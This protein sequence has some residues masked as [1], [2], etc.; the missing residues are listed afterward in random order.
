ME[1]TN[2]KKFDFKE[3][4]MEKIKQMLNSPVF[5]W[6]LLS[7]IIGFRMGSGN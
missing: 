1:E 7:F 4:V 2:N 3:F 6:I 5:Y